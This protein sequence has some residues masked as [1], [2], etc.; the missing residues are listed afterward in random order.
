[1]R[2]IYI[3]IFACLGI[4]AIMTMCAEKQY[5]S[6]HPGQLW[7]DNNGV[8]INA[9]GGGVLFH[10]NTYYWFGEHKVKGKAG[11]KAHVGVH[12]YSSKDLYNW[13]DE[14]IALSVS[15]DPDNDIAKGCI[16]E[17]PK[18]IY[19]AGTKEF[20]MWFH[21][22]LKGEGYHSARCGV[23]VSD[24]ITG[25]Y[26]FLHS[27]RPNAGHWPLNV[28][29][30]QKTPVSISSELDKQFSGGPSEK[31]RQTN[32]LGA[33]FE[34]GQM[35]RDMTLFVDDDAKAYHLYAS[36]HN[37]TLHIALLTDDYLRHS[38]KY[39]RVFEH[40]WMEALAICKRKGKYY[41]IASGCTGWSPNAARSAVADSLFGSWKE[42]GNPCVG[43]GRKNGPGADKTFGGQSTFI[44]PVQGKNDAFIAMFD[45]WR[46]D[47]A[48]DGRYMWL[49]IQFTDKGFKIEWMEEW[50]LSFFDKN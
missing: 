34:G 5:N 40:R 13:T 20:V 16:L 28:R 17:R 41:L 49:P 47:N 14:G 18:V 46:P 2:R 44:L 26:T 42:L 50:D 8:H 21:L 19:N 33:H 1:M 22:E 6:F 12:V 29:P 23:A 7:L 30:E 9:H 36:E 24:R 10:E 43:D 45:M 39:V 35:S 38:G 25:P 48:I 11:N 37:S 4:L 15:D 27:M 3:S 31:V 32:I